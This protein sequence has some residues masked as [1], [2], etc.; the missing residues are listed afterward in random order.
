MMSLITMSHLFSILNNTK[1][2]RMPTLFISKKNS[3]VSCTGYLLI[4]GAQLSDS[5]RYTCVVSNK[6][7]HDTAVANV[8]VTGQYHIQD[9]IF[10]LCLIDFTPEIHKSVFP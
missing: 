9:S 7:G 10:I 2:S 1:M 6:A 3:I 4:S 5:G 8:L